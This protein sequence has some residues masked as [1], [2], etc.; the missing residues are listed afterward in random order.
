MFFVVLQGF[1]ELYVFGVSKY[2]HCFILLVDFSTSWPTLF[3]FFVGAVWSAPYLLHLSLLK[4]SD[5]TAKLIPLSNLIGFTVHRLTINFLRAWIKE[6]VSIAYITSMRTT[7][8]E[9]QVNRA[10]YCLKPDLLSRRTNNP[11]ICTPQWAN[12]SASMHLS[13]VKS[14]IL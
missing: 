12:S 11:N 3:H 6:S 1:S 10:Q 5:T 14:A 7:L 9:K 4:S 13:F 8:L 2:H